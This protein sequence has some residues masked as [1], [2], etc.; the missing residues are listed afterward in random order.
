MPKILHIEDD[1]AN[2]LLVRKLLIPAG[3]EIIESVDGVDGI[4]RACTEHPDL[5]LVDIAIP[6]LDGY[7]VTLRLRSEPTLRTTPIIAITAEGNRDTSLAV[8]CD[9]YLQKP[10]DAR[11]FVETI[12]GY[13]GGHREQTTP[14]RTRK[15]LRQQS[16]RIV[17]HL[18]HKIF[19]LEGANQRLTEMDRLRREFY[20]NVTHELSTPMTPIVGYLKLL[21]DEELGELKPAQSKALRA[22][23]DCV[24]R[25]R[26]LIDNLLDVTGLET[27][28]LRL[29]HH[30]YDFGQVVRHQIERHSPLFQQKG[31]RLAVDVP[32][33]G[34]SGYGD[35][36]RLARAVDHLLDNTGK[37][38][39]SGGTVGVR[40]RRLTTG[41]FELCVADTGA[42]LAPEVLGRLFEPFVQGDGSPTRAHGG[43]GVGLAIV[44]GIAR[45]H[46]GDVRCSS[47]ADETIADVTFRGAAFY[48]LVPERAG[49]PTPTSPPTQV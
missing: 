20:R 4:H 30:D 46:G 8:G 6:G 21:R 39:G 7:E 27:G 14:D 5:I 31:L 17:A 15:H 48:L 38:V 18:E 35:P 1:P 41:H 10:I 16:Q 47:P 29:V 11:S 9:G 24:V 37:F 40:V 43:T 49:S 19:E 23:D 3:F 36:E 2:R 26:S 28:R 25:L 33:T 12:E 22:M 44:R 32:R 13:L 34:L 45:G 42:G